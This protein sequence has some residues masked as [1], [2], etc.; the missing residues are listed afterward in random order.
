MA[1]LTFRVTKL[2]SPVII[3]PRMTER[4]TMVI[5]PCPSSKN[6]PALQITEEDPM[7]SD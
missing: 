2:N 5:E 7:R 3:S 1:I 4:Y 6:E